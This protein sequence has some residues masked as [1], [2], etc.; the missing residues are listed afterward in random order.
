MPGPERSLPSA[1]SYGPQ[2]G[3]RSCDCHALDPDLSPPTGLAVRAASPYLRRKLGVALHALDWEP[4]WRGEAA[5]LTPA[6]PERLRTLLEA[7]SPTE[8]PELS[9][10]PWDGAEV[11]PW[12][13][14]PLERW[15]RR[16]LSGWFT[17]ASQALEFHMQPVV[18]LASGQVYGYE[19]LVRARWQGDLIGAGA[20]LDAAAARGQHRAFDALAR[21]T[22]IR[23]VYPQ[24]APEQ[25]LFINFAPGVVYDPNIC[26]RTTF[27]ACREVGA[28]FG[29]LLFEVT[30]SESFPDLKLLAS[31]L[32]RYRAEGAQVA[33]D[34][35]GAGHTSLTYLAAL[36]PDLVKL[37]RDLIRNLHGDDARVPLVQALIRYAHDLGIRTVAEGVETAQELRLV[38]ELGAD[39]AQGY[40]LG[41]P[42]P[43][44]VG[45]AG[46]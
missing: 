20:L 25:V 18:A 29:R 8:R 2:H 21:R 7:F 38:T 17:A 12:Q 36:R 5:L 31:I 14:A 15:V 33:L 34:D 9:A 30:E 10:A 37:D 6:V 40:L 35:L 46:S 4:E 41:R 19:A 23:Q 11:D 44:P 45:P 16:L 22:A 3:S 1:G 39:Y 13:A 43:S 32:E 24:L 26:L 42:A 27:E 28:D